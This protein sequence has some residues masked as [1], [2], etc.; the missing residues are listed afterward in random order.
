MTETDSAIAAVAHT[1]QLSVA[2]VFLLTAVGTFLGVLNTR[3]TRIVDRGRVLS[4]RMAPLPEPE[5]EPFRDEMRI[6]LRRRQYVNL[7]L[8][9][10]VCA[11]LSVC[12][13]IALAFIGSIVR[14]D[15]SRAVAVLFIFA[16]LSIVSA[17]LCFLREVL[18]AVSR[19]PIEQ[20]W[21]TQR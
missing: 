18:L 2:P 12:L 1:I 13:L 14:A 15:F 11:A 19:L 8:G 17:L 20:H 21:P 3:L 16:M 4:D 9:S 7:A 10:G 6:L 5:R